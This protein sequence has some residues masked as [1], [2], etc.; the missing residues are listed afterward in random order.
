MTKWVVSNLGR[1]VPMHFTAFHP[2]WKMMDHPHTPPDTLVRAREIAIANG[3]YYA[4]VGNVYDET[5]SS[6][7]CYQCG[8]KVIGRNWYTMT[9]WHLTNEGRCEFCDT[10]C[11]GVFNGPAGDW[12]QKRVPVRLADFKI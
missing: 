10:Q 2:D 9:E 3:V 11:H 8:K 7:Y 4:Y 5:H 12:G 6:T 1:D